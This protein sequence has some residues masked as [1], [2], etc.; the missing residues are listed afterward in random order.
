MIRIIP[1]YAGSTRGGASWTVRHRDHPRIRG[2]HITRAGRLRPP[3]G[4]SPHTRGARVVILDRRHPNRIIPA[5]AGSTASRSGRR[6]SLR[7]HPRI[8]GEHAV[9]VDLALGEVRII[10]A[11]AGST[12]CLAVAPMLSADHPRIRGEHT[13]KT[14]AL[15]LS[16]GSSP[17]T[18]GAQI[19]L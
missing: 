13:D 8:R 19:V 17:H 1:A 6:R 3:R 15:G 4:S 12:S 5:Y 14:E 10:P 2:E 16:Q 11:Y 9:E 18:R 7:D